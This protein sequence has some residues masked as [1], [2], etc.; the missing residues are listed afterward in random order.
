[1]DQSDAG[2]LI[3]DGKKPASF[4]KA[5]LSHSSMGSA[6]YTQDVIAADGAN[7]A[8]EPV[9]GSLIGMASTPIWSVV[10]PIATVI[11]CDLYTVDSAEQL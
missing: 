2:P 1:M 9:R 3:A 7:L 6:A 10:A 11:H 5:G 8:G 4:W